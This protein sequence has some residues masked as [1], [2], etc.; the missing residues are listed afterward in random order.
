MSQILKRVL[1]ILNNHLEFSTHTHKFKWLFCINK[2]VLNV[3]ISFIQKQMVIKFSTA[4][5]INMYLKAK[6][7][8]HTTQIYNLKCIFNDFAKP[9][10]MLK[11]T[12]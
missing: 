10:K 6:N 9:N 3:D 7:C 12:L 5:A 4:K 2:T 11:Y 1:E 8:P